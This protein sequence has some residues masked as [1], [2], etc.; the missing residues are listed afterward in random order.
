MAGRRGWIDY[1]GI[2][3]RGKE[4]YN[5]KKEVAGSLEFIDRLNGGIEYMTTVACCH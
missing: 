3:G 2:E 5:T 4:K 1:V